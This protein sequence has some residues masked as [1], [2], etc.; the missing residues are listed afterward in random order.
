MP[1]GD[2]VTDY[3]GLR[4]HDIALKTWIDDNLVHK[5]GTEAETIGGV[6]TYSSSP[7]VPTPADNDDSYKAANT[8]WVQGRFA[9]LHIPLWIGEGGVGTEFYVATSGSDT[10]GDGSQSKPWATIRYAAEYL[11]SNYNINNK[12]VFINVAAGTYSDQLILPPQSRT[13]GQIVIRPAST[14]DAVQ[15][16]RSMD[17]IA[18][19]ITHEG[20]AWVIRNI[21][22]KIIAAAQGDSRNKS[23]N[24]VRSNSAAGY[25][26]LDCCPMEFDDQ[27]VAPVSGTYGTRSVG[28]VQSTGGLIYIRNREE[29]PT[30]NWSG[31]KAN[32]TVYWLVANNSGMISMRRGEGSTNAYEYQVSGSFDYF[33]YCNGGTYQASGGGLVPLFTAVDSPTGKRYDARSGGKI[34]T[35]LSSAADVPTYFPGSTNGTVQSSTYSFISPA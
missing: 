6:K 13:T 5:S 20:G 14:N 15:I 1:V 3:D 9:A 25:L 34:I 10:T 18:S 35:G 21:P 24:L 11:S 8:E 31:S 27:T 29:S 16:T 32:A 7:L 19:V 17:Q 28:M 12:E 22:L 26:E 30:V 23:M 4:Q 2:P 33:C